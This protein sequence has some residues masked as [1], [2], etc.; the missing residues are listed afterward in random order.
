MLIGVLSDTHGSL[1]PRLM[2]LFREAGVA[3]ILHAGDV[4]KYSVIEEL[5]R[6][7]PV[8]VVRGNI[9]IEGRVAELPDEV[10]VKLAS[11][12]IYMTHI[13][14]KPRPWLS[15][16][17]EPTPNI[18]IGGHSHIALVGREGGVLFLNPG[19]AGT[20]PRFGGSLSAA[21][22]RVEDGFAEAEIVIF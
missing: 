10:R 22:L 2:P 12:D 9:D 16:L 14:G 17:P 18:A 21:L 20:Q 5:S 19:S 7:A 3:T 11:T 13:G 6:L 4:G 15:R 8:L 1:H